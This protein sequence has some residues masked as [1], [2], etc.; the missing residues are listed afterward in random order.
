MNTGTWINE[1]KDMNITYRYRYLSLN[2]FKKHIGTDIVLQLRYKFAY[3]VLPLKTQVTSVAEP[4]IL[5]QFL[6]FST[7]TVHIFEKI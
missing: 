6:P 2:N 1:C 3:D 5:A 4:T 7:Y